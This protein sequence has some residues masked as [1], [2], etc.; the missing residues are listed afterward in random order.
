MT[1]QTDYVDPDD[2]RASI[3]EFVDAVGREALTAKMPHATWK[4]T[5]RGQQFHAECFGAGGGWYND[6]DLSRRELLRYLKAQDELQLLR[7][8]SQR[9]D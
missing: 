8:E 4:I 6:R 2:V 1:T 7:P 5:R 3:A 9:P